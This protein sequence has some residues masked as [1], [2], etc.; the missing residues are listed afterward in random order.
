MENPRNRWFILVMVLLLLVVLWWTQPYVLF[1][2][3]IEFIAIFIAMSLYNMGSQAYRYSQDKVLYFVSIGAFHVA[4]IDSLHTLTYAGLQAFPNATVNH[5]TQLWIA[6]RLVQLVLLALVPLVHRQSKRISKVSIEVFFFVLSCFL[7]GLIIFD[8][9][10]L[11]YVEGSGLTPFKIYTE[12]IIIALVIVALVCIKRFHVVTNQKI[13]NYIRI[14]LVFL[15]LSELS[16]TLYRDVY[17]IFN[18]IGHFLKIISFFSIWILVADEG[19]AKP[20][21]N[22]FFQTYQNSIHDQLTG[23][24]NRRYFELEYD[25]IMKLYQN[26]E[27]SVVMTDINGLKLINDA[28]GHHEGDRLIVAFVQLLQSRCKSND[29]LIRIGGDEFLAIIPD[30]SHEKVESFFLDLSIAF[31]KIETGRITYSVSFGVATKDKGEIDGKL[32]VARS[33]EQMYHYKLMYSAKVKALIIKRALQT[34]YAMDT[35]EEEHSNHVSELCEQFGKVMDFSP[36]RI[37]T[38]ALA[39]KMH[40]IG[41]VHAWE[42]GAVPSKT[43]NKQDSVHVRRHTEIGFTI[44][45]SVNLYCSIAEFVLYHHEWNNGEGYPVGLKGDDIP[46]ESRMIAIAE[47]YDVM[48]SGRPYQRQ[49]THEDAIGELKRCSGSQFDPQLVEV[50]V[51][52]VV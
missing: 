21:D 28:F 52:K 15:A 10:P 40:D 8:R 42:S 14:A 51:S 25:N 5:T 16:F 48:V 36:E 7:I 47:A 46:V 18:A 4:V 44:L 2:T 43:W 38:L 29:V 33:E 34:V 26:R 20:Y 1:H 3:V 19:Y 31:S 45:S 41:K 50:F 39:G 11:C 32:L 49:R 6:G 12:Y 37:Q 30:S 17:G 22:L 13:V 27:I 9:F 24:F 23:L 35:Y